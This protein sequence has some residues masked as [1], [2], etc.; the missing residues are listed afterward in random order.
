MSEV[1]VVVPTRGRPDHLAEALESVA[2]ERAAEVI[3]LEDGTRHVEEAMVRGARLIR[4]PYVGRAGARNLGVEA[5]RTPYVAFLDADDVS[6]P[7]RF[8]RQV[9]ALEAAPQA[10]LCFGRVEAIDSDSRPIP[11][12]TA[13]ESERVERLFERGLTY[14]SML[15]DCP[16]YTSSTMVRR[17]AFLAV[18][19]YDRRFDGYEDLDLYLRLA[20]AR[21]IVY[22]PGDPVARHRRHAGNTPSDHLYACALR[23]A[24]AHLAEASPSPDA[25]R[26]LLERRVDSLWGLGDFRGARRSALEALRAEPALLRDARFAKR[27]AAS[28]LPSEALEALRRLRS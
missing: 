14:E 3:V 8:E 23:L 28:A 12:Q 1:T 21:R 5:A 15:V 17:D 9:E 27:L 11:K 7:G 20:R 4:L 10:V 26:R 2:G 22:C 24:E 19:G 18:G 6:L 16:V 25:R 13:T